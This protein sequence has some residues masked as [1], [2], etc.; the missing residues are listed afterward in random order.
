[1]IAAAVLQFAAYRPGIMVWD[2]IRQYGQALSGRFDDWH[3]PA[4]EWLWRQLLP[5]AHGPI[6]ML[7]LQLAL[8]WTGYALLCAAA[9]REGRRRTAIAL[10][11]CALLPI[12]FALLG[13][14]LKDCLM[15]GALLAATGLLAWSPRAG[16]AARLPAL[17]LLLF[18]ATIRFNAFLAA[19]PIAIALLPSA[20]RATRVRMAVA[21]LVCA[22]AL[23]AALPVVNRL[24]HAE[25]SGV[26]LSLVIFDLGGI[27]YHSGVNAFP[28]LAIADPVAVNR[29]CYDAALWDRYAWWVDRPCAIGFTN[30]RAAL[31]ARHESAIGFWL[32]AIAGHPLAYAEHRLAHFNIASAFLVRGWVRRPVPDQTDP[33]PWGYAL[34]PDAARSWIDR[35]ARY[36]ALT[37]LGWP[38]CWIALAAGVLIVT[39][40]PSSRQLAAPLALSALLYGLGYV[41]LGVASED[42]YQLWTMIA[43]ALAAVLAASDIAGL[44]VGRRR[45]ALAAAPLVTVTSVALGWRIVG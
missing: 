27:T 25:H 36:A 22:V 6:A 20:W 14:V 16:W 15:A 1:M 45:I 2:A 21:A 39:P 18:A 42:R 11:A 9:W 38:I 37:P 10:F 41:V 40:S 12:P 5:V 44:R 4:M 17:L 31:A 32:R 33:N 7:A 13:A 34:A 24:L 3:P 30:V 29:G 35:S 23:A 28:P 43:A 8:Y 19:L 26:E